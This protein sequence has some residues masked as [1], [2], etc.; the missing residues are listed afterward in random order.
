MKI[1]NLTPHSINIVDEYYKVIKTIEP[2]GK[3]ARLETERQI[4]RQVDGISFFVTKYGVPVLATLL[5][6]KI[7]FPQEKEGII[8]IVPGLFRAGYPRADLWQPGELV[9]NSE[10]QPIGCIGLSQ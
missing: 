2:S 7:Q 3:I 10:G 9:R 4:L 1:V 6:K 8:Y 5:D